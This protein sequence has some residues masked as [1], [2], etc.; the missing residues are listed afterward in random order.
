MADAKRNCSFYIFQ[1]QKS[2]VSC[3]ALSFFVNLII[4]RIYIASYDF[5]RLIFFNIQFPFGCQF[6]SNLG[7]ELCIYLFRQVCKYEKYCKRWLGFVVE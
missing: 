5:N 2:A 4:A 3:I 1:K 6:K 7:L